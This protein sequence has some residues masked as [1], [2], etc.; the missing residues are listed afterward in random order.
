MAKKVKK[1]EEA[2]RTIVDRMRD[3]FTSLIYEWKKVTFPT[4]K[5]LTQA[6]IVVFLFTI[7]LML[8]ISV[9]DM[10]MS[11]VFNRFVLPIS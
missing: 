2:P 7:L 10:A 6:T 1:S 8:V 5:E 3:Y 9:Y 11:M 4:R